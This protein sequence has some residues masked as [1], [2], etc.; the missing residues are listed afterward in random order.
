MIDSGSSDSYIR[1]SAASNMNLCIFP[2][3]K[4]VPLADKKSVA[5][6][7][8]EVIVDIEVH[9][10]T[11]KQVVLEVIKDLCSSVIIGRDILGKHRRVVLNFNGPQDDLVIGAISTDETSTAETPTTMKT[12]SAETTDSSTTFSAMDVPPPPL[13]TH[14]S[15]NIKPVATKSR[16]QSPPDQKFINE[17]V[18][19]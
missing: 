3:Q 1:E 11:H 13:F 5:S 17:E 2:K 10:R 7:I 6:I 12:K 8:G 16:R 15:P 4:T 9:G 14:L 18:H 19:K